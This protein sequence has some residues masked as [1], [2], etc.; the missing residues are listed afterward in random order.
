MRLAWKQDGGNFF[1]RSGGLRSTDTSVGFG[2]AETV[3]FEGH[4]SD[5]RRFFCSRLRNS[6]VLLVGSRSLAAEVGKN[7][8]LSG[9]RRLTIVGSDPKGEISRERTFLD[10]K[11]P[12]NEGKEV[13]GEKKKN[14]TNLFS[15]KNATFILGRSE[16]LRS[17]FAPIESNGS[18]RCGRRKYRR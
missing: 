12:G 2:R 4:S 11:N 17:E 10:S 8:V 1:R 7:V 6:S 18:R 3:C 14:R 9:V 5:L 16:S 15:Q 13:R